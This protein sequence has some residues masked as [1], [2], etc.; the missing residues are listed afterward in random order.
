MFIQPNPYTILPFEPKSKI[1]CGVICHM[2]DQFNNIFNNYTMTCHGF[3][4]ELD[5]A[6]PCK[7]FEIWSLDSVL[8]TE[9]VHGGRRWIYNSPYTPSKEMSQ[10]NL[11]QISAQSQ[12]TSLSQMIGTNIST[13]YLYFFDR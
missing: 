10:S 1:E 5:E 3:S 11:S 6:R 7:L 9:V 2:W 8:N 13:N 4:W 12:L